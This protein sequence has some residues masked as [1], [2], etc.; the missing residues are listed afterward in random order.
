M[1]AIR[2]IIEHGNLSPAGRFDMCLCCGRGFRANSRARSVNI[3][4][5]EMS[6]VLKRK[7]VCKSQKIEQLISVALE[8]D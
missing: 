5:A 3:L 1:Q 6:Y 7:I 8:Q 4:P 2:S